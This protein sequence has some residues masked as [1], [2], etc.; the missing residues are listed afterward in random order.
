MTTPFWVAFAALI[1]VSSLLAWMLLNYLAQ[2]DRLYE[3]EQRAD[4]MLKAGR[5][6]LLYL[7]EPQVNSFYMDGGWSQRH[8]VANRE[9]AQNFA[10]Q[11]FRLIFQPLQTK[12]Q[13]AEAYR[14]AFGYDPVV[15]K[16][17]A[18]VSPEGTY[19]PAPGDGIYDPSKADYGRYPRGH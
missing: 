7:P 14:A 13:S 18:S 16:K 17:A 19:K 10:M 12:E 15:A 5:E 4:I 3:S 11:K 2:A 6:I 8:E 1:L 9:M